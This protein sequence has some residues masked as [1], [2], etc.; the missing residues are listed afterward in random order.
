MP[1]KKTNKQKYDELIAKGVLI[2]SAWKR[3][4]FNEVKDNYK[5]CLN[6]REKEREKDKKLRE[7][8]KLQAETFNNSNT[9]KKKCKK[10]NKEETIDKFDNVNNKCS[11]CT[12]KDRKTGHN[13]NPRDRL[14]IRSIDIK[15]N[16]QNRNI[17]FELT[18]EETVQIIQLPCHY[19]NYNS[20]IKIN[21]I[22][23]LDY[24]S[25]YNKKNC[26][27]C[28]EQCNFMKHI[29]SEQDFIKICEHIATINKM[30]NGYLNHKLFK[31][32]KTSNYETY[33]NTAN[34]RKIDFNLSEKEF[35]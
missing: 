4:C 16:A 30:Y 3:G 9:E 6:C 17:D 2:C 32:A 7:K 19:C 25:S 21:G 33:Q 14:R 22:D 31:I 5:K 27:S 34:K 29:N 12:Q 23:R 26:V 8:K 35:I 18:Y 13:R 1:E 15:R 10:C 28:C 20:H 24:K 11:E